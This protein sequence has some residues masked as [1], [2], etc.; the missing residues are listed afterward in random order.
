M[1]M[2]AAIVDTLAVIH[3]PAEESFGL[4]GADI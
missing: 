3:F 4:V 1:D 2:S